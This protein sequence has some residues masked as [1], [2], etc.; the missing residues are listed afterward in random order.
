M[1]PETLVHITPKFFGERERTLIEHGPLTASAFVLTAASAVYG[2][3]TSMA[4]SYSCLFRA[5][6]SGRS[7]FVAGNWA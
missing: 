7:S 4:S 6:R 1:V 2:S 3:R 5:N